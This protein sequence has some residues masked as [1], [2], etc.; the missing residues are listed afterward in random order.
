MLFIHPIGIAAILWIYLWP[1]LV[2]AT[3]IAWIWTMI[4]TA[5]RR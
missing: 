3:A 4:H 2:P 5:T 1:V